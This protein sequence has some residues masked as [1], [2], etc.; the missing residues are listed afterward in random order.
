[1]GRARILVLEDDGDLRQSLCEALSLFDYEAQPVASGPEAIAA[2]TRTRFDLIV[3]DVRMAGMDGIDCLAALRPVQPDMRR[4]VITGY[5]SDEAPARAI[6]AQA[7]DYLYKPFEL[8]DFIEAV[9]R[10]LEAGTARAGYSRLLDSLLSRFRP[11]GEPGREW[12]GVETL[13]DLAY[14]SF[15][16]G[17]RSHKLSEA[18]ALPLWDQLELHD[19]HRETA[20]AGAAPAELSAGYQY[21]IDLAG[22]LARTGSMGAGRR[23]AGGISPPQFSRLWQSIRRGEL[24]LEMLRLAPFLRSLDP[25]SLSAEVLE[26]REQVWGLAATPRPEG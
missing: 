21:V 16:V 1:M 4:I 23:P 11:R 3:T 19:A 14:Q 13:R 15:Y 24:S 12:Q 20:R 7:D 26:L 8:D 6:A 10:V 2:A 22:A 9:R 17:I 5:A 18:E 25:A